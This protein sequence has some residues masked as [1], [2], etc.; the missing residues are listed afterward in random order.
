MPFARISAH[1]LHGWWLCVPETSLV[2]LPTA[3]G[4]LCPFLLL[5]SDPKAPVSLEFNEEEQINNGIQLVLG[6]QGHPSF[7][8]LFFLKTDQ[9]PA[10][11]FPTP[12]LLS[13]AA[14]LLPI[15]EWR[16]A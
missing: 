5:H 4:K 1:P 9:L 13:L 6:I 11:H 16:S 10:P 2:E 14:F 8:L 7:L 15:L 3:N 12:P